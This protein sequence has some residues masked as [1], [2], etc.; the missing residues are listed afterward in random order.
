MSTLV[1]R[2]PTDVEIRNDDDDRAKVIIWGF[3]KQGWLARIEL[4]RPDESMW[5]LRRNFRRWSEAEGRG[6]LFILTDGETY[7]ADSLGTRW[8]FSVKDDKVRLLEDKQAAVQCLLREKAQYVK[9]VI[10]GSSSSSPFPYRKPRW[11]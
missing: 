9:D 11:V 10:A 6:K 3:D 2:S 7:E 8:Y 1:L 4:P 5:D